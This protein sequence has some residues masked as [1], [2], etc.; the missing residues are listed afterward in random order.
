MAANN[1]ISSVGADTAQLSNNLTYLDKIQ[2]GAIR[3]TG[4]SPATQAGQ[5][6]GSVTG[7]IGNLNNTQRSKLQVAS[8]FAAK[9]E[10]SG[11]TSKNTAGLVTNFLN[12]SLSRKE[13]LTQSASRTPTDL[14][15][16][17]NR[18][19]TKRTTVANRMSENR[20]EI[21]GGDLT[22]F[23]DLSF[24][25]DLTSSKTPAFLELHFKKYSRSDPFS[26]G[27][28]SGSE[29]VFLP[30][31]DNFAFNHSVKYDQRDTGILGDVVQSSAGKDMVV[32]AEQGNLTAA[33]EIGK[34]KLNELNETEARN[35]IQNVLARVAYSNL[36]DTDVGGLAAQIAGAIPNP[37]PSVFFK[38]LELRQFTWNWKLVPRTVADANNIKQIIKFLKQ[39]ILPS[40]PPGGSKLIYPYLLRPVVNGS[41]LGNFKTAAVRSLMINFSGEGQ[42]A[43]FIDGNPVSILLS[44]EFQEV[45]MYTAEDA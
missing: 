24:P 10:S 5:I 12:D 17:T 7:S 23:G 36:S 19:P 1:S 8:S 6:T 40:A 22:A 31:P 42:S 4:A 37:H 21:L 43:F 29:K 27:T 35:A 38:G 32:A 41:D 45:E 9:L 14:S 20:Q 18:I 44:M 13:Q 28:L 34:A 33:M 3:S 39:K 11:V 25:A 26:S 16:T 15:I 2:I 30:L